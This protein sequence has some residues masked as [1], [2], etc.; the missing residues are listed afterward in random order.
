MIG[1][2]INILKGKKPINSSDIWKL[3]VMAWKHNCNLIDDRTRELGISD[4]PNLKSE[5]EILIRFAIMYSIKNNFSKYAEK[6]ID[7][8]EN[9]INK[10]YRRSSSKLL[11]KK[12][13]KYSI[14]IKDKSGTGPMWHLS[15]EVLKNLYGEEKEDA[16]L[17][18][19]CT[20]YFSFIMVTL[21]PFN[22]RYIDEAMSSYSQDLQNISEMWGVPIPEE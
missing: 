13:N 8:F 3:A 10:K 21:Q 11:D 5:S 16:F 15:K 17:V 12:L 19:D 6:I 1:K 4:A 7:K 20:F 14:L 18:V 9:S 22:R 2:I